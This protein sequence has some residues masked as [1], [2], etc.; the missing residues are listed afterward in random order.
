MNTPPATVLIVDDAEHSRQLLRSML[1]PEGY[2]LFEASNGLEALA[3]AQAETPEVILLDVMMPELNG[4]ETCRRLRALP[5]LREVSIM[6]LTALDDRD[7]RLE[8]LR[9]GADDFITKPLDITELRLRLRTIT[10]LSR[11]R[12]LENERARFERAIDHAPDGL[13]VTDAGGN[14]S[15]I[16]AAAR[17]MLGPDAPLDGTFCQ[18]LAP[19]GAAVLRASIHQERQ[20]RTATFTTELVF[21][22]RHPNQVE[23]AASRLPGNEIIFSVR[24]VTERRALEHQLISMQRLEVLGQLA[25]GIVHDLN[26]ILTAV[27]GSASL[28]ELTAPAAEQQTVETI[29]TS[30]RRGA[31]MLRQLLAFSRGSE[32]DVHLVDLVE[33]AREV[34]HLARETFP[35]R[36]TV[37]FQADA[38]DLLPPIRANA[39]QLH[40]IF[41][42]LS[43]NARDAMPEGGRLQIR[44]GRG[45][46]PTTDSDAAG[47]D[48]PAPN[49]LAVSVSDTGSG[50]SPEVRARLF[51][52]FFTTKPPGRG[53]GLGLATVVRLVNLHGGFLTLESTV[54]TGSTFTCQFPVAGATEA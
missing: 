8:G 41:M 2:R 40:Q 3:Q 12:A 9:A 52:P 22:R 23:I 16:N 6:L 5:R 44:V 30:S 35:A 21:G 31:E 38:S 27:I 45:S 4:F 17:A 15:L 43:V 37:D 20:L 50:I 53:T 34:A 28:L 7:S 10:R 39:S 11:F 51:E 33:V 14:I 49:Y 47:D 42:N 26:N 13:V 29:L 18:L 46:G 32:A 24:D 48:P 54:G 19:E 25:G 36:I 1:K